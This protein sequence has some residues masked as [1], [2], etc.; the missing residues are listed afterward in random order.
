MVRP[1]CRLMLVSR[2]LL[3]EDI[4]GEERSVVVK[5]MYLMQKFA[6]TSGRILTFEITDILFFAVRS[7]HEQ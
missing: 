5:D 1:T 4:E 6:T 7:S 3:R 2:M